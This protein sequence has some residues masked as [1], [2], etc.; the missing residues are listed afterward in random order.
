MCVCV[1]VCSL[2]NAIFSPILLN[3]NSYCA[4]PKNIP[5]TYLKVCNG[6]ELKLH[7]CPLLN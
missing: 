7:H 5:S 1:C 2:K 4:I 3:R 6:D